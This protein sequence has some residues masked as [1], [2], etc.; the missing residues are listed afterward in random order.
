MVRINE[1]AKNSPAFKAGITEGDL[2][3]SIN[4]AP[5]NDG[6]DYYFTLRMLF[7]KWR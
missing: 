5:I 4:G 2:L 1:V 6:L 7:S 3:V